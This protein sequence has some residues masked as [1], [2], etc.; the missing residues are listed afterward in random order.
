[1]ISNFSARRIQIVLMFPYDFKIFQKFQNCVKF[2]EKTSSMKYIKANKKLSMKYICQ[3]LT[4]SLPS[5][6]ARL[7]AANALDRGSEGGSRQVKTPR[8]AGGCVGV[9][10][11]VLH[12]LFNHPYSI[13][14]IA[15]NHH[16]NILSFIDQDST[17]A[18]PCQ[19][20]SFIQVCTSL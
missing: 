11:N 14:T 10:R 8:P 3:F 13:A 1:M 5:S 20:S 15:P 4:V 7:V 12:V 16:K 2:E 17:T 18:A 19:P 6:F 9:Y